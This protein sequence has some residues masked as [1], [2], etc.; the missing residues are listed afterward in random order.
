MSRAKDV[1][2]TKVLEDGTEVVGHC[3][4]SALGVYERHGWTLLDDGDSETDLGEPSGADDHDEG[5]GL[6][7]EPSENEE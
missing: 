4:P 1:F 6:V 5:V 7:P 2:I 3:A